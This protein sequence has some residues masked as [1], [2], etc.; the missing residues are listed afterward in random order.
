MLRLS[1]IIAVCSLVAFAQSNT[2]NA[3]GTVI[4]QQSTAS[5]LKVDLSG[6]ASN[7]TA[8]KVD[9]SAVTQ[10]VSGTV[11]A[12]AAQSGTWT[13]QPGNTPNSTAWIFQRAASTATVVSS[14]SAT[15]VAATAA[16]LRKIVVGTSVASGTIK[17]FDLAS[18][19][20]TGTPSTNPKGTITIPST[21]GM[22]FWLEFEA[23]FSNGICVLESSASFVA[24]F[25]FN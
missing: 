6:T 17:L 8:V 19:S 5:S 7:A 14:T 3:A 13:V 22:P 15:A 9:G 1:V 23:T 4:V 24:T 10:P 16:T 18:A 12:N 11:T 21:V 2:S 25:I 20:C